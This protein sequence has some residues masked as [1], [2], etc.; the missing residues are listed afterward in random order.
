MSY[1][2][3]DARQNRDGR[4][5]KWKKRFRSTVTE[6]VFQKL[7][8]A[9]ALT[10]QTIDS[11]VVNAV[12]STFISMAGVPAPLATEAQRNFVRKRT[13]YRCEYCQSAKL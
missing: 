4:L 13:D 8:N 11:I 2:A 3:L 6:T 12:N 10:Q 1:T 9:A 7:Q 5:F